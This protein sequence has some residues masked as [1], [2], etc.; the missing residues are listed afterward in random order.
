MSS[1]TDTGGG[2]DADRDAL[3]LAEANAATWV[4]M[5]R[6]HAHLRA[7]HAAIRTG[8][9]T[10][11]F[12]ELDR[13]I[14]RAASALAAAG[15]GPGDRVALLMANRLEWIDALGGINRM[16]AIA[17]PINFRLVGPEVAFLLAD[18]GTKVVVVD[19]E[20][21]P[22]AAAAV[23]GDG[24][25]GARVLVVD[26][27]TS[28]GGPT[29]ASWS[30]AVAA[31]A[32][33][34][35]LTAEIVAAWA[36]TEPALLMYTSGTTGRPKGAVLTYLN[37]LMQT[38]TGV[39]TQNMMNSDG[40]GM[41]GSP[42]FHI[43][44]VATLVPAMLLGQTV[45]LAGGGA[46]DPAATLDLLEA[47]GVTS[48]FLVPTQWQ[49]ICE[50]P[51]VKLRN[52]K[53]RSMS[54]GASPAL[55]STLQAM[56]ES[57]PGVPNIA[58]FGQTEM[59]PVTC[60]LD[61]ADAMRKV[62]SVGKPIS[63][64]DVRIV[65]DEMRD[66]APGEVGEIVYRGPTLMAGYW[67]NPTATA[68]AMR[69]GWFHSGDLVRVDDEGFVYV[70]DRKKDMI[71]S[72]GENIYSS[73]V[74]NAIDGHPKVREVAVIGVPHPTWVE[75]PLA[76]V[77]PIDP[78][79]PPS[80]AEIIEWVKERLASYKKPGVVRVVEALPRNASGKVLKTVLREQFA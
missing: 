61:G 23:A 15:V 28:A 78:A 29:A 47:E 68:D 58:V 1:H 4:T 57:F 46:F 70:V 75:T 79:D 74:E 54:W 44:G 49:A 10:V 27:D 66:V 13:R 20:R 5:L 63:T 64:V 77:A 42:L 52:L 9:R 33:T 38:L 48:T 76:V 26:G 71:I 80:E 56:N 7:D 59:S 31:A 40:V 41:L 50:Q 19:G 36:P 65:D 24:A 72:G 22:T 69:G 17:V 3:E 30:D 55:P 62:G 21:A 67:N 25:S 45:L 39:R 18:S 32:P 35:P 37:L 11:T 73:E 14:D 51:D 53:L 60:A 2:P 8:G 16:G 34:P 12:A 6:R 43:A